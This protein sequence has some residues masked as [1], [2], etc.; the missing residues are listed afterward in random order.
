MLK[1]DLKDYNNDD[2]GKLTENFGSRSLVENLLIL[3]IITLSVFCLFQII[4]GV[5][6][7]YAYCKTKQIKTSTVDPCDKN[8]T[9]K[10]NNH[11]MSESQINQDGQLVRSDVVRSSRGI[12]SMSDKFKL[13]KCAVRPSLEKNSSP[14]ENEDV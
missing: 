12:F 7:M 1:V 5:L 2:V 10:S 6:S 8:N 4:F 14:I 13:P 3:V 9:L 11:L